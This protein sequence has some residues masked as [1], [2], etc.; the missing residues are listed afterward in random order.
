MATPE[1][2]RMLALKTRKMNFRTTLMA[3]DNCLT[4][5]VVIIAVKRVVNTAKENSN[6]N[7]SKGYMDNDIHITSGADSRWW[8][9]SEQSPAD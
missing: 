7:I 2:A 8:S 3:A 6:S 4:W 1:A 5:R 9:C